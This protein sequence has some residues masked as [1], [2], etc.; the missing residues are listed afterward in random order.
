[1]DKI[2]INTTIE[3]DITNRCNLNCA[4]CTHL[5]NFSTPRTHE[6]YD[7]TQFE[8]DV[9][10]LSEMFVIRKLKL[11]GGEP[12]LYSKDLILLIDIILKYFPDSVIMVY[13]NGTMVNKVKALKD[14]LIS[15]WEKYNKVR[16]YISEYPNNESELTD[17]K[18]EYSHGN[19][20]N[21]RILDINFEGDSDPKRSR[22]LCSC[23]NCPSVYNGKL[24]VCPVHKNFNLVLDYFNIDVQRKPVELGCDIYNN[25]AEYI[26]SY[27]RDFNTGLSFCRFCGYHRGEIPWKKSTRDISEITLTTPNIE[28][29]KRS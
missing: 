3:F 27:L 23:E 1:M 16:I 5:T 24:Y 12:F 7:I 8:S 14:K 9:K 18:K 10:R 21:F 17:K 2:F 13:T 11:V 4:S 22:V 28:K 25:D 29:Y 15:N 20:T 19:R 6:E 26:A